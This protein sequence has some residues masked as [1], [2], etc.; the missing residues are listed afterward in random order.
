MPYS[1]LWHLYYN[2]SFSRVDIGLNL[3]FAISHQI[4]STEPIL[5]VL[6]TCCI[7]LNG[8]HYRTYAPGVEAKEKASNC[9]R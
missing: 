4:T 9:S 2:L 7:T 8:H 1:M 6:F 3:L 5:V